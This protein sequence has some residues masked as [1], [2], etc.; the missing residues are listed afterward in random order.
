MIGKVGERLSWIS[1]LHARHDDDDDDDDVS[2]YTNGF[3]QT[4]NFIEK[5]KQKIHEALYTNFLG[6]R[7]KV[8]VS[9]LYEGI[10]L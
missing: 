7:E 9:V 2:V 8:S 1:V 6:N 5:G 10:Y 3:H 4:I